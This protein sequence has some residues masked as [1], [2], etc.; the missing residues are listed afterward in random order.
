LTETIGVR[1][2]I[3][4]PR[5]DDFSRSLG[6]TAPCFGSGPFFIS[7]VA[8]PNIPSRFRRFDGQKNAPQCGVHFLDLKKTERGD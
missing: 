2:L 5:P 6:K 1:I 3:A 8:I 7:A 4:L